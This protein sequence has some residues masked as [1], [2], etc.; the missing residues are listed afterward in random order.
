MSKFLFFCSFFLSSFVYA[1]SVETIVKKAHLKTDSKQQAQAKAVN[2]LS[3]ELVIK[4]IGADKYRQEKQKVEKFIIKNKNRYILSTSSSKPVLQDDGAF[5]STVTIKVSK[6]NLKDLLLEQH[7]FY[8]SEGSSC[9]LPVVSFSSYFDEEKKSYSWWLKYENEK[10]E[11]LKQMASSFFELLSEEFIKQG[12]YVLD[13]IFQKM[14]E[15]TPSGVLPKKSSRVRNFVPLAEFYTCDIIL[16]GSV[17]IGRF[18][19]NSPGLTNFFGTK[20][21]LQAGSPYFVQFFFN[22]FNIK[23]RQFLFKFKKQFTFPDDL[24]NKPTEGMLLHLKDV[25]AS[26]TYQLSSYQ[27]EG[28]LDLSRLMISVQG[29]L[30]YAQKEQL[31]KLLVKKIAGIQNLEERF[32]TSNRVVYAAESSHSIRTIA[33]QLKNASLPGFVI[34]VKGYRKQELEIY[35]KSQ[36]R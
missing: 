20:Q 34:Q 19:G 10:I 15:G 6:S 32:L 21:N 12:F 1:Q 31:K 16:S 23:T 28:S 13:P 8:A 29:P 4:M 36:K 2:G 30:T 17:Q 27:E 24:K 26:L 18:S 7:L 22:V 35:A 33:K 11:T 9:L 25:L 14:D 5:S 3:R